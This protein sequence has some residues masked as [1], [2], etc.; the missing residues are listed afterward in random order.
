MQS[1]LL[2]LPFFLPLYLLRFRL[3]GMLPTTVLE[4][5]LL[6]FFVAFTWKQG[7]RGWVEGWTR[8]G[9]WRWPALAWFVISL[10]EVFV[11][12]SIWTGFGL[13]RAYVLEPLVLLVALSYLVRTKE[14][15]QKIQRSLFIVVW[16]LAAWAIAQYV[17]GWGIP[18]P[19]DVAILAGRRATG[20]FSY[21]NALSLFAAPLGALA[22]ALWAKRPRFTIELVT[23]IAAFTTIALA[24]SEGGMLAFLAVV[25]IAL[26]CERWGRRV[27]ATLVVLG[28]LALALRPS[29]A[30]TLWKGLSF[31][32]WSGKVRLIMWRETWQMLKAHW[33]FGAGFGGYP[34]VFAAFHKAKF[35]EIFQ[36]PHNILFNFWSE[37]GLLGVFSF[38]WIIATW[39]RT[40]RFRLFLLAP[41]IAIFV[42][43][44]VDV[45]YFKNDLAILFW[46]FVM[47]SMVYES[48]NGKYE[49]TNKQGNKEV[50]SKN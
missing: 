28:I 38:L 23:W 41:L 26:A 43:G 13:W 39:I 24:R 14:A 48:T 20:P 6:V 21:P 2:L 34:A 30:L 45:P 27:L 47:G 42:Q 44:L 32:E 33:L 37:T 29:L 18:H 3:F 5:F 19:Y 35:I 22:F 1:F 16:I 31:Q 50:R 10:F 49:Y 7:W 15:W 17:T 36:Y 25:V 9:A 11:S 40:A 8:L 4:I 12:P 46:V